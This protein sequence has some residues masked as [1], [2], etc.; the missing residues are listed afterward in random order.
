MRK[1]WILP[2]LLMLAACAA[3]APVAPTA[4]AEE[5]G[6]ESAEDTAVSASELLPSTATT[7]AQA[8]VIRDTDWV[9]GADEPAVSIIEYG[10]F[11]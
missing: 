10:D 4:P 9:K 6:V 8:A 7:P 5:S 2:L 11:Q 1:I 3:A